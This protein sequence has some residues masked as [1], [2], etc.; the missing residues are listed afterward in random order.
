M[1]PVY[2]ILKLSHKPDTLV[3]LRKD[4]DRKRSTLLLKILLLADLLFIAGHVCIPL[5]LGY[6]PDRILLDAKWLGF[7]ELFQYVKYA[8][9]IYFAIRLVSQKREFAYVPFVVLFL[10]LFAD[11]AFQIH[12]RV[13]AFF[14]QGLNFSG[15]MGLR[16]YVIGQLMF[17]VVFGSVVAAFFS[18]FF[19]RAPS[20]IKRTF[21]D[22]FLGVALFLFFGIGVDIV[23]SQLDGIRLLSPLL[24]LIEEGG[25]MLTLS[26]LVWYFYFLVLKKGQMGPFLYPYVFKNKRHFR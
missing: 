11:D 8:L 6:K 26:L 3:L 9:L 20:Y 5:Y 1:R 7:P 10:F 14:A 16:P 12:N 24:T 21:I 23:H 17:V 18:Y 13:S 25:E 4:F 15:I 22:I 2:S 19:L